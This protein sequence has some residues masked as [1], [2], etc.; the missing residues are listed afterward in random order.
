VDGSFVAYGEF[1]ESGCYGTVAFEPVDTA[2]DSVALLVDFGVERRWP[3]APRSLLAPVGVLIGLTR[4]GGF[5]PTPAQVSTVGPGR[6]CLVGQD[7]VRSGPGRATTEAGHP[8]PVKDHSELRAVSPLPRSEHDRERLLP[9]LTA[10]M[11]LGGQP[12]PGPAQRV[13]GRL[14]PNAAWWFGLQIPLLRAPAAC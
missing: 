6:V 2:L 11:Q 3:A 13:V 12:A 4:D 8:D 5:D 7:P 10:Q 14:L 9:L 1:V